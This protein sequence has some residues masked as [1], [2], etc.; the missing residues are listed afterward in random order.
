MSRVCLKP[1]YKIQ[2]FNVHT[3][4]GFRVKSDILYWLHAE[5]V[6]YSWPLI[7]F[8]TIFSRIAH[9]VYICMYDLYETP[10]VY[11]QY[12]IRYNNNNKS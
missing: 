4:T 1:L 2:I 6:S 3:K 7:I 9:K 12:F 10:H 8:V 5:S 11:L